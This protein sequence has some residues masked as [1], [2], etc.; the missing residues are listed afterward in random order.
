MK[1][2]LQMSGK[3]QECEPCSDD[4]INLSTLNRGDSMNILPSIAA[5]T[6]RLA[7]G[8]LTGFAAML[9]MHAVTLPADTTF[10]VVF[11]RGIDA[12]RVKPGEAIT[13]KT[14]QLVTL[15]NGEQ[16]PK[17]TTVLGHVV[18]ASSLH[19]D[20]APY[21]VQ[22]PSSL[23][24]RFD[25]LTENGQQMP[26]IVSVRALANAVESWT[27][28]APHY[29]DEDDHVGTMEL[30]GGGQ[31]SPLDKKVMSDDQDNIIG[32]NK[33]RG[34]YARLFSANYVGQQAG[35]HCEGTKTEQ[36]IGIFSPQACGIYGFS[37]VSLSQSNTDGTF[38][39]TSTHDSVKLYAG[40]TALLEVQPS[41]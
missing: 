9:P 22:K 24:I 13:A 16:L 32:Y 5:R 41:R 25:S 1:Q 7:V 3:C 35:F 33:S 8:I 39:L 6:F 10:P 28:E 18:A 40:S 11:T 37:T 4:P 17:G 12:K 23:E 31:Y 19:F 29:M 36:A 30:I 34:V 20:D 26:V 38:R 27:A 14:M 15:T 21:A 2:Q